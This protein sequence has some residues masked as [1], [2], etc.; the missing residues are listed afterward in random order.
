MKLSATSTAILTAA[1]A[2]G[3]F[4]SAATVS[5]VTSYTFTAIPDT[6]G[7]NASVAY[8]I[9]DSGTVVGFA[10]TASGFDHAFSYSN[11]TMTDLGT[12]GGSNSVAF[13]INDSGTVVGYS[14]AASNL[15]HAFSYSNGTMTDLGTFGGNFSDAYGINDSGTVVGGADVSSGYSH[16]FSYAN[17]T[18]TDLGTLGGS[19]SNARGINDSGTVV[20]RCHGAL[21]NQ[22]PKGAIQG[23]KTS[24]WF[25]IL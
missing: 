16:A 3:L 5:A 22:P 24:H 17:G 12:L 8:G 18:M 7:G 14:R 21:Q 13:G 10:G 20:G 4:T 9:N 19:S 15:P 25:S 23:F 1:V 11:G 2:G 6:L